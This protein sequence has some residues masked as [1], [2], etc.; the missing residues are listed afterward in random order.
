[1]AETKQLPAYNFI[2]SLKLVNISNPQDRPW[3]L[4]NL[5]PSG[6]AFI[7]ERCNCMGGREV[8]MRP[9]IYSMSGLTYN[10]YIGQCSC[11]EKVYWTLE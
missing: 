6:L 4:S 10:Y 11:C 5:D 3:H 2:K 8:I 9:Y 7:K 1:M